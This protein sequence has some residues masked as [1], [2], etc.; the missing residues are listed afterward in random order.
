MK[1]GDRRLI[2]DV[3]MEAEVRVIPLLALKMKGGHKPR[4]AGN[5]QN[6][7]RQENRF[8]PR[9]SRRNAALLTP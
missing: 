5:L 7:E 2:Q 3:M 8:S 9:A 6:L 4:N 1:V